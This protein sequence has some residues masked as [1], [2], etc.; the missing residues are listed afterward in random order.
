M[1]IF[2][3]HLN[4]KKSFPDN[5]FCLTDCK[6]GSHVD[7]AVFNSGLFLILILLGNNRVLVFLSFIRY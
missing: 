6:L 1:E 7:L 4:T 5:N 2:K 3:V